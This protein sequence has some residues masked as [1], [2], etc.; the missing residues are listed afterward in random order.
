M[1]KSPIID[2]P[3]DITYLFLC[4]LVHS[5]I[6]SAFTETPYV[7]GITEIN[8]ERRPTKV[9]VLMTLSSLRKHQ[10][11]HSINKTDEYQVGAKRGLWQGTYSKLKGQENS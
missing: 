2:A 10:T 4:S 1:T 7:P 9:P 11:L 5:F 8:W 3:G 6:H